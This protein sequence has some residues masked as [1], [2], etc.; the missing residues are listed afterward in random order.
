MIHRRRFMRHSA[1]ATAGIA[2]GI[3][4]IAQAAD[5]TSGLKIDNIDT[6]RT[7]VF[8]PSGT[9]HDGGNSGWESLAVG[10]DGRLYPSP[11]LVGLDR[12]ATPLE[13]DLLRA[14]KESP[15]LEELRRSLSSI[16]QPPQSECYS[17]MGNT[18]S[19]CYLC[20]V[21]RRMS[22]VNHSHLKKLV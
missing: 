1:V 17:L 12:A 18:D 6:H 10:F 14:W 3:P 15:V 22:L 4:I 19:F 16:S 2:V 9:L 21:S 13:G 7:Q 8:A 5:D 20:G 11:A